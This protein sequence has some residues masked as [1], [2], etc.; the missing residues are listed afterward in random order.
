VSVLEPRRY[1]AM[2]TSADALAWETLPRDGSRRE[3]YLIIAIAVGL[4][5]LLGLLPDAWTEGWRFYA[6]GLSFCVLGYCLWTV[7]RTLLAYRRARAR[8]PAP[9]PLH[10]EQDATGFTVTTNEGSQ[11]HRLDDIAAVLPTAVH[12]F[13]VGK[14]M[15]IILPL[16]AFESGEDMH[17]TGLAIEAALKTLDGEGD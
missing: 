11:R 13:L 6:I 5:M 14:D 16:A 12:L 3:F 8:I 15:L 1:D 7:I 4:G 17:Q 2:L 9:T 10:V